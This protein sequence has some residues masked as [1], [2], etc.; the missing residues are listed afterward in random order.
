VIEGGRGGTIVDISVSRAVGFPLAKR[1]EVRRLGM[2]GAAGGM[3]EAIVTIGSTG[4]PRAAL[5]FTGTWLWLSL[6]LSLE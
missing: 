2:D 1:T 5:R 6:G 4:R 3:V